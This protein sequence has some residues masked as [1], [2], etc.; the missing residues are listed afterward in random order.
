[1][2]APCPLCHAA[3][4]TFLCAKNG[5][6]LFRCTSCGLVR[7]DPP[8]TQEQLDRYYKE[9]YDQ[10]RYSFHV[11]L[12]DPKRRKTHNLKVLER[13]CRPSTLLDVGCAYGHFMQNAKLNG[14]KAHGVEP[15]NDARILTQS[16]FRLPVFTSLSEAP[17]RAYKAATLWHVIEHL[18][19]PEDFLRDVRTK[20][21]DDGVLAL[22]TPNVDSLTAKATGKSWSWLS[23]P[24]HLMLYSPATLPRLLEQ[25]GF[26]V[27]YIETGRG[28]AKN[29]LLLMLQALAFRLGLFQ[30]M[31]Q[32]VQRAAREI[33]H[34]RTILGRLNL[35]YSIDRLT[36]VLTFILTPL[37]AVL[38][39]A[40]LGD[41]VLA[42]ARKTKETHT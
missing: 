41:E 16:R 20:L 8:P 21:V 10:Y 25:C 11:P 1:M 27:L 23:P 5:F 15:L 35:F 9:G 4:Q 14:W 12:A 29:I 26:E 18:A 34:S 3:T 7:V 31:K 39:K 37:L 6:D 36:E 22:A 24:D 32:S 2:S 40:G 38:W 13:F 30:T 19:A 33:Q 42:I 17:A 28:P